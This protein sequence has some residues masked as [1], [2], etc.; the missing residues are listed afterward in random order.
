MSSRIAALLTVTGFSLAAAQSQPALPVRTP[1]ATIAIDPAKT[2]ARVE[3]TRVD[4]APGQM[5]PRHKHTVPVVCFVAKGDFLV[6]IGDAPE[7]RVSEGK[8]T[9][10]PPETVVQYFRN[11][12]TTAAASLNCVSLAGRDDQQLNVML[13]DQ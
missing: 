9:Y 7:Q 1:L 12:S 10:E 5:M 4:F 2:V 6:R 8:V 3:A 13:N 11:A